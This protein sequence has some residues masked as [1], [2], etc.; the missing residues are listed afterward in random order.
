MTSSQLAS[1]VRILAPF[2]AVE[3][4]LLTLHWSVIP[5][6]SRF[7]YLTLVISVISLPLL[8][9]ARLNSAGFRNSVCV[10]SALTFP[11]LD[12]V[13][14][15]ASMPFTGAGPEYLG[16]AAIAMLFVGVPFQLLFAYV[17]AR[18]ARWFTP[19]T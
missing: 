9:A 15:A 6:S 3:L 1:A 11:V 10:L 5:E 7:G 19:A 4:V 18:Y 17:G 16:G 13:W 14:A 8:A 12:F 2:A